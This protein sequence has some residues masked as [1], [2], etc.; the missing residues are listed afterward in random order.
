MQRGLYQNKRYSHRFL[1]L[2][3]YNIDHELVNHGPL[4][5]MALRARGKAS[6]YK[7]NIPPET[8]VYIAPLELLNWKK[9]KYDD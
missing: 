8:H 5:A 2:Y 7:V 9:V 4:K 1:N 6:K 3:K